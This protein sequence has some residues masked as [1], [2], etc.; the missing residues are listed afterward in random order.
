MTDYEKMIAQFGKHWGQ[1]QAGLESIMDTI[2][3]HESKGKNVYQTGGGPGAGL[4]QYERNYRDPKTGEMVQAGGMTARNRLANWYTSQEMDTPEWLIQEGMD[5]AGFDASL[6]SPEQ[7]KMLFLADKRYDKTASLTKDA[8]SDIANWWAKEHWRGGEEGSDIYN[9]RVS[10]FK[11]D[12]N[13]LN[14]EKPKDATNETVD[15]VEQTMLD[16]DKVESA[17]TKQENSAYSDYNAWDDSI[18]D[19]DWRA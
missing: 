2:A 15:V 1:D 5:E 19:K 6:L 12:L 10:S 9:E 17:F 14:L 11:R 8:T 3:H 4:F 13:E 18:W 7:Q 16:A